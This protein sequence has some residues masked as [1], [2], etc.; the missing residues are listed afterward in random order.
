MICSKERFSSTT[1]IRW[2]GRLA[3]RWT[4]PAARPAAVW[5]PQPATTRAST[6]ITLSTVT[7]RW[8]RTVIASQ[9]EVGAV[10]GVEQVQ[11]AGVE[12]QLQL[13]ALAGPAGRVEPGHDLVAAP[14]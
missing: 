3:D 9:G 14:G 8:V 13:P 5:L 7:G 4:R 6:A 10:L 2:A 1:T 11:L 12:P